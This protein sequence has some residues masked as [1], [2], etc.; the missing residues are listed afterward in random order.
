MHSA[1]DFRQSPIFRAS[2]HTIVTSRASYYAPPDTG[3]PNSILVASEQLPSIEGAVEILMDVP[4]LRGPCR[5]GALLRPFFRRDRHPRAEQSP[6][7]TER[8]QR[9]PFQGS[10]RRRRLRGC[11]FPAR[12]LRLGCAE[13]PPL[14]G[15]ASIFHAPR[16]LRSFARFFVHLC[17]FS[18]QFSTSCVSRVFPA[19]IYCG[20]WAGFVRFCVR[21]VLQ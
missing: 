19:T 1:S 10:W 12:P 3:V 16:R 7:P 20:G 18:T 4:F 13:P 5:G 11:L 14:Q 2:F 17:T 21:A 6:A 8:T 15:E 9:L